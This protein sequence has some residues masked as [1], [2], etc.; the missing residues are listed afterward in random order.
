[1]EFHLLLLVENNLESNI[2]F[3]QVMSCIF[4]L[5]YLLIYLKMQK[6][7]LLTYGNVFLLDFPV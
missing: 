5:Y 4:I 2:L 6:T 1:M 3:K 7:K